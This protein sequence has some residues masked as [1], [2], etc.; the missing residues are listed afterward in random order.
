MK[1]REKK[2]HEEEEEEGE[3]EEKKKKKKNQEK[4][5]PNTL[6]GKARLRFVLHPKENER[7]KGSFS[8]FKRIKR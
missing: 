3:E 8:T 2:E 7:G 6:Q 4:V 5:L 1:K